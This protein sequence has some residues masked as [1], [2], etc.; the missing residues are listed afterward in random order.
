MT[1]V[2]D[3][4][5]CDVLALG[6]HPD[7]I[8]IAAA[9]SLLRLVGQGLAVTLIDFTRGE[10]GSLGTVVDRDLEAAAAA[11][12]LGVQQRHNLLLP[13]TG[14]TVDETT[15]DL[16]VGALRRA[17]PRL[18][19]SPLAN[20]VHPDHVAAAQVTERAFFLAGLKHHAPHLGP[21]WRPTTLLRYAG[22][23]PVNPTVVIDI[24]DVAE[25]KADIIRCYASQLAPDERSHL[26]QGLDL[27]ERA[28]VRDR[29]FG[30]SIGVEAAEAFW[31]QGP[32]PLRSLT[33]V[34]DT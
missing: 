9:G 26:T 10:K 15:T 29:F 17:R 14:I 33:A 8:E 12:A 3:L 21:P 27:L 34:L 4:Q 30:A 19:L 20:D 24:S 32:L 22:N 13:D 6:P 7:D 18:L 31:H 5:P 25:A 16:L 23:R 11:Q 1:N 2:A 28:R